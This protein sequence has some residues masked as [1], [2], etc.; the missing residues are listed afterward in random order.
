[1]KSKY[2]VALVLLSFLSSYC[3]AQTPSKT[4]EQNWRD[5]VSISLENCQP[6]VAPQDDGGRVC[7]GVEGYSL[8]LKGNEPKPEISL[9]TPQGQ[10]QRIDVWNPQDPGY[11]AL[12][13][14]MWVVV[15]R[16]KKTVAILFGTQI[17]AKP[18]FSRWGSYDV[19]VRVDPGPVCIVGTVPVEPSSVMESVAI[20]DNPSGRPCLGFDQIERRNWFLTARRLASEGQIREAQSA[21]E[22]ITQPAERFIIY[23]EISNAQYRAN[24]LEGARRTLIVGRREALNKRSVFEL[25]FSLSYIVSGFVEAGFYDAAKSDIK[26]FPESKRLRMYISVAAL[27]GERNDFEAAKVTF[28]ETVRRELNRPQRMDWNLKEICEAQSRMRLID[29]ARQ[30]LSLIQDPNARDSCEAFIRRY[31]PRPNQ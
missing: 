4:E 17:E 31:P 28:R 24:D 22:K 7:K 26:L 19:I 14:A 2:A 30:T 20:A 18:D 27:Q 23:R 29:D 10:R 5:M 1:M 3:L 11:Q 16:P 6:S 25:R 12:R 15:H 8:L 21:L 13:S 9:I